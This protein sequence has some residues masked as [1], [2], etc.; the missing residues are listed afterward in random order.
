VE[1]EHPV[2]Y[3][4]ILVHLDTSLRCAARIDY[5]ARL[6]LRFN[7]H[8]VGIAPT[9]ELKLA[10]SYR[11][12]APAIDEY[13]ASLGALRS[14]AAEAAGRFEVEARRLGVTFYESRQPHDD[15]ADAVALSARYADLVV[16]GQNDPAAQAFTPP[17]DL[18][19]FTIL[20]G[21]RPVLLVPYAGHFG[22]LPRIIDIAWDASGECARAVTD[23]LPLLVNARQVNLVIVNA[24]STPEGHGPLPGADAASFLARHGIKVEVVRVQSDG[25]VGDAL[26][27]RTADDGAELLVMGGYGHSRLREMLLGG[28]TRCIL[29]H[30]TVP[31]FMAH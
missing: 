13:T 1:K 31:V 14:S 11:E 12:F 28:V 10:S 5:A 6:A 26:L 8:L 4:T 25:D 9:D 21:G 29:E 30:M 24:R 2:T 27:S 23:A 19:Q 22:E 15:A 3:K 18:P 20:N 7:A 17:P 16:L